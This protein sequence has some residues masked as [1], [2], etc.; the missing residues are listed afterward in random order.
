MNLEFY[1]GFAFPFVLEGFP[2]VDTEG[3]RSRLPLDVA[4]QCDRP[5]VFS[6]SMQDAGEL[7][8]FRTNSPKIGIR[9]EFSDVIINLTTGYHEYE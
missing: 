1:D 2:Y 8:R 6:M 3:R 4:M 5:G 9:A 7:L